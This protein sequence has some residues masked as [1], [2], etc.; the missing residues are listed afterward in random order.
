[1]MQRVIVR[2]SYGILASLLYACVL[3]ASSAL[4]QPQTLPT[5]SGESLAGSKNALPEATRG[6][7]AVL[8]LGFTHASKGPTSA[9]S[10]K[11]NSDFSRQQ[12]FA[13]YDLPVLEDVPRMIRGMVISGIRK[14]VPENRRDHFIPILH[15]E[16]ELKNLV[17]YKEPNDAYL[18]VLD[19]SGQ[20]VRQVHGAS[21]DA[22][23]LQLK[24]EIQA[25]LN[26]K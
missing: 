6:K 26:Q 4:A 24:A 8:V 21:P 7:V 3:S 22:E 1:M 10:E 25:L 20:I 18:I 23:Y 11:L 12:D 9:W 19:R 17:H 13:L 2:T 5:M 15:G 16:A 14:G